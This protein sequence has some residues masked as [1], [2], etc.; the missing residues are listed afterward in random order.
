MSDGS[1]S[2]PPD[3][4]GNVPASPQTAAQGAPARKRGAWSIVATVLLVLSAMAN[5]VLIMAVLGMM[6]FLSPSLT[7]D[8][9]VQEEVIEKGPRSS[10]IAIIRVEGLLME[11]LVERVSPMLDRAAEDKNVKAVILRVNS[12]GGG[13]TASDNLHHEIEAFRES[14]KPIVTAMDGV[15]ASGGYYIACATDYV[16]AQPT[17]LTGS[18]G[19][20]AEMFFL[21]T[22]MQD[23]LG[24]T[25]VTLKMG[26][27]KDWPNT[28]MAKGLA[29]EQREYLM[30]TLLRPGYDRFVDVV[31]EGREMDR[32]EVLPL[33]TGR[34]FLAGEACEAGLVDEVGYLETAIEAAMDLAG[35]AEARVVEY[36][37]PPTLMDLMGLGIQA[38]ECWT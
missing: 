5:L 25:P 30:E 8:A 1:F 24:V 37:R 3:G 11:N 18:I 29:P 33:A 14:G 34:I 26:E 13:L 35:L 36:R 4:P 32:E 28:F 9:F 12:P 15:A 21:N 38:R 17:T 16:V 20:V 10:K 19:I 6:A 7:E 23:K 2:V 31:A 22:L 27:Q